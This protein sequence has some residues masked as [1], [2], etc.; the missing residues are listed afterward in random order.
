M[1]IVIARS[2]SLFWLV[3]LPLL[4][5]LAGVLVI[6]PLVPLL[7]AIAVLT[8][9]LLLVRWPWLI[10]VSIAAALPVTSARPNSQI[11]LFILVPHASGTIAASAD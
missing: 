2:P 8:G 1:S 5:L 7:L 3:W 4:M 9:A 10:W 11:A 6:T